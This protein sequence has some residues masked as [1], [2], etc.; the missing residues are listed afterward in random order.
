M[1]CCGVAVG[2]LITP[3]LNNIINSKYAGTKVF[4]RHLPNDF[5]CVRM[6]SSLTQRCIHLYPLRL[7]DTRQCWAKQHCMWS[8]PLADKPHSVQHMV[9]DHSGSRTKQ[10]V[11]KERVEE[12]RAFLKR[13]GDMLILPPLPGAERG[14]NLGDNGPNQASPYGHECV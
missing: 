4:M 8:Q 10:E 14:D 11:W 5:I 9:L 13:V 3:S 12:R 2:W 6:S 1:Y 7:C